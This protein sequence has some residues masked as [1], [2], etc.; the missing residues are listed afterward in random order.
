M[1]NILTVCCVVRWVCGKNQLSSVEIKWMSTII[2][3]FDKGSRLETSWRQPPNLCHITP[4]EKMSI[5]S[6]SPTLHN[7]ML[8]G[9]TKHIKQN[10]KN[11]NI[12]FYGMNCKTSWNELLSLILVKLTKT[13]RCCFNISMSIDRLQKG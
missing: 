10:E 4:T 1:I 2:Y 3:I 9:V 7:S 8:S 12:T 13:K 5:K 6:H 11:F